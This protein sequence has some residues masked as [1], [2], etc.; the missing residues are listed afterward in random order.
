MSSQNI[1]SERKIKSSRL[2]NLALQY[3]DNQLIEEE[4]NEKL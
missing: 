3:I 1:L 2:E 4:Y